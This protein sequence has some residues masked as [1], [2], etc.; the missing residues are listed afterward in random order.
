MSVLIKI[1]ELSTELQTE[2]DSIDDQ[3]RGL[4]QDR[5][6]VVEMLRAMGKTS[7]KNDKSTK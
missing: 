3:I 1:E 5:K 7:K 4:R 2:L 6:K